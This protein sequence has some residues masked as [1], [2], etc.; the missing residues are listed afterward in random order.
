M[1]GFVMV[2]LDRSLDVEKWISKSGSDA[3]I[4]LLATA[5]FCFVDANR[6]IG[7]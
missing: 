4:C 3:I 1:V 2:N 7:L 5:L 6:P